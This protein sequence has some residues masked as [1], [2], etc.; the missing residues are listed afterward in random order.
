M[1]QT[2]KKSDMVNNSKTPTRRKN[3]QNRSEMVKM[4]KENK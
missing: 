2:K 1:T 4:V 3:D